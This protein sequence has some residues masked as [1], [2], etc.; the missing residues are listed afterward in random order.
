MLLIFGDVELNLGPRKHDTC[1][2]LFI[3]H[4][5]LNSITAHKFEKVNLLEAYNIVIKFD[6]IYLSETYH[7]SSISADNDN[8]V[9]KSYKLLRND[10][11]DDIKKGRVFAYI[12]ESLPLRCFL[13]NYLKEC[14]ILEVCTTT[15]RGM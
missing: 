11:P 3:C 12:R 1:Y 7:G 9:I 6:I 8:L 14:L 15:K 5:N 10:H 13:N 4:C 2:N